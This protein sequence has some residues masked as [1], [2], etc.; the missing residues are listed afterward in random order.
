KEQV[1]ILGGGGI[2]AIAAWIMDRRGDAEVVGLINDVAE[3][4]SFIGRKKKFKVIGKSEDV[5]QFLLND[6]YKFFIAFHGMQRERK[7]YQKICSFK[8][9]NDK[10]YS[11]IDP[12]A[13]IAY[14]YSEVGAGILVAPYAQI[15]PDV[16]IG[17]NTV[18]LGNAFIGHDTSIG[19]FCHIAT[20][21][22]VG[23]NVKIGNAC[24]IGMNATLREFVQ[25][26]DYGFVGMSAVVLKDVNE[27]NIVVGNPAKVLRVKE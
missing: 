4:G 26:E 15:G 13:A 27:N 2:A 23:S 24:H 14:E 12:T 5:P 25:I 20:N 17:N 10:L 16:V 3:V 8:I 6:D 7:T 21:A 1:V 11:P 22:V 18:I 19:N 9:P